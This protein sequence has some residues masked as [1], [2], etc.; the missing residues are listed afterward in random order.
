M[1]NHRRSK[2]KR[3]HNDEPS[4]SPAD[5]KHCKRR[6]KRKREDVNA[7]SDAIRT[8]VP[9]LIEDVIF[10][11]L[12]DKAIENGC[13]TDVECR[14]VRDIGDRKKQIRKVVL[15][16]IKRSFETTSNFLDT[17]SPAYPHIS[18]NI[19]H[20]YERNLVER[21]KRLISRRLCPLCAL[22][23]SVDVEKVID[24]LYSE[25]IIDDRLYGR[26]NSSRK[27]VGQQ[28]IFLEAV[29]KACVKNNGVE[30]L[31]G[32]L[33]STGH[34]THIT[35]RLRYVFKNNRNMKQLCTC[36]K[37]ILDKRLAKLRTWSLDSATSHSPRETSD[38]VSSTDS[39]I[40]SEPEIDNSQLV[41][42]IQVTAYS[43]ENTFY[44]QSQ[45]MITESIEIYDPLINCIN[46]VC[47]PIREMTPEEE[48]RHEPF[49][50]PENRQSQVTG[51]QSSARHSNTNETP[52][53]G[54]YRQRNQIPDRR[55]ET[56]RSDGRFRSV[57]SAAMVQLRVLR[58]FM[59]KQNT[60][61]PLERNRSLVSEDMCETVL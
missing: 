18:D 10:N 55:Q 50:Q 25:Q 49:V 5:K 20:K 9:S 30:L 37:Y 23:D 57:V 47:D 45:A 34:Y 31:L 36:S 35:K 53:A 24:N 54:S 16:I 11:E 61:V 38:S 15:L 29:L 48:S 46:S 56:R 12:E 44:D 3:H 4:S 33:E 19:W 60:K 2:I 21:P 41:N 58:Q 22:K 28:D 7:L 14:A 43:E 59:K 1:D 40:K 39:D 26:T 42:D 51:K 8:C 13:L 27:E 6:R 52:L 17:L 32:S